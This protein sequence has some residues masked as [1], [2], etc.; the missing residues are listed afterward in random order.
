MVIDFTT[1]DGYEFEDYI[2]NL[3]RGLGFEVEATNYSNDGGVDLVA[4][5]NQPIFAGKY[6]IQCKN[7][8]SSVGQPEVRDLYGVVMDQRA[9]K[10]ILIT[11][12]DFTQQ[13]YDFAKGKNIELINGKILNTIIENNISEINIKNEAPYFEYRNDRYNYLIKKI[14]E[15]PNDTQN[16]VDLIQFLR[17]Y[18]KEQKD[19]ESLIIEYINVV[20]KMISRCLKKASKSQD[21]NM[22]LLLQAEAYIYLGD[23]AKA[24][25]ILV[26]ANKFFVRKYP[27]NCYLYTKKFKGF[28]YD[29]L[30]AWNLYS[31]YKHIGYQKG[32]DLILSNLDPRIYYTLNEYVECN[33]AENICGKKFIFPLVDMSARGGTTKH[34]ET[35]GFYLQDVLDTNYFFK[36]YYTKDKKICINEIEEVLIVNGII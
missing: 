32:C 30:Y 36:K 18:I 34:L 26:R 27:T 16:Y 8:T 14:N 25:E 13:A 28:G 35:I 9:N 22:A 6:I 15:E 21:K 7:W 20:E 12:S 19:S 29:Y 3:F 10:G 31:A 17:G 2:S 5:Y 23:L 4:T 24:T 1:M 33:F 11:P